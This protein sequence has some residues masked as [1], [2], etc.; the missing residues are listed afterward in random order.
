M[1]N[2][3]IQADKIDLI[4]WITRLQDASV[5]SE[6]KQIQA[7]QDSSSLVVPEWHQEKVMN[8]IKNAS[9]DDYISLSDLDGLINL[10]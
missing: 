3:N 10:D 9:S 8:R 2:S 5:L 6:L 7:Q 1:D 4:N